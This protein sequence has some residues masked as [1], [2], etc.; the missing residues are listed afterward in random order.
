MYKQIGFFILFF[1][2]QL[3]GFTKIKGSGLL[4]FEYIEK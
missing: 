4:T 3:R 2:E 1:M